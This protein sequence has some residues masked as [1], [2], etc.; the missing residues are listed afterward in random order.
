M[1]S[2]FVGGC[3]CGPGWGWGGAW[4]RFAGTLGT[5]GVEGG[6]IV[7]SEAISSFLRPSDEGFL[8]SLSLSLFLP[9]FRRGVRRNLLD[10]ND[11][12]DWLSPVS[13]RLRKPNMPF[14]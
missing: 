14:L 5:G 9:L 1:F 4:A 6:A 3:R 10:E 11:D 2:S 8:L 12:E 13:R 7:G